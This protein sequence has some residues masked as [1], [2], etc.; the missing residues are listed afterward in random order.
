MKKLLIPFLF[1]CAITIWAQDYFYA[2]YSDGTIEKF[3]TESVDSVSIVVPHGTVTDVCGNKYNYIHIGNLLWMTANIRCNKRSDDGIELMTNNY[4]AVSC[5]W[6]NANCKNMTDQLLQDAGYLYQGASSNLCPQ[7]WRVPTK[8]DFESLV[9]FIQ[10]KG[11]SL[12]SK[13]GWYSSVSN[14]ECDFNA[15]PAGYR[16]SKTS[17]VTNVGVSTLYY[18]ST[19]CSTSGGGYISQSGKYFLEIREAGNSGG[20]VYNISCQSTTG[21]Q[22]ASIRCCRDKLPVGE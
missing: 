12:A 13:V 19:Q 8:E 20:V 17:S 6:N 11:F 2:Y 1:F 22:F 18:S 10:S 3:P 7:G 21:S 9:N 15:L 4:C 5:A 16:A 14:D